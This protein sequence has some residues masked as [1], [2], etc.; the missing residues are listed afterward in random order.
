M[1]LEYFDLLSPEPIYFNN[2]GGIKS[3]TLREICKIT[4]PVY[5][6]YLS[7]FVMTPKIYFETIKQEDIFERLSDEQKHSLNIFD[8]IIMNNNMRSLLE[9][10]LNFFLV[11]VPKCDQQ[12]NLIYLYSDE[13]SYDPVGVISSETWNSVCDLILQRNYIKSKKEDLSKI[14][15]K[16]AL[17]IMKKLQAGR[18]KKE[19]NNKSKKNTDI[20]NIISS[21]ANKSLSLNIINIWDITIYQ[22]WDSFYR[23]CNNNVYNIQSMSAAV[24]GNETKQFDINSWFKKLDTDNQ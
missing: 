23:N 7:V 18:E 15:S 2:I 14:K 17:A 6:M 13:K 10:A 4:Y 11:Y 1:K 8:L 16:K 9:S 24:Y 21:V 22:L 5:Q 19:K 12:N 3:P 20:G